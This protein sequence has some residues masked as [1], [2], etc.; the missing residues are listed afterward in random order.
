MGVAASKIG[1]A[2]SEIAS[3]TGASAGAGRLS[4]GMLT[5]GEGNVNAFTDP[6]SLQEGRHY[7][8]DSANGKTYR[9]KYTGSS[10]KTHI[11]NGPEFHLVGEEGREA[12]IDAHTTRLMQ[13]DDP[14]IWR[15][16]Q[17]LYNGGSLQVLR[18]RSRSRG[19]PAF[20]DGNLDDFEEMGDMGSMGDTGA[21]NTE[22]TT[23][24]QSVLS[25]NNDLLEQLLVNGVKGVFDVYGKGGL[26]DSYDT[27]KR[28]VT[29]YG[30][31]Y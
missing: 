9:A 14:G 21:V 26:V 24:L 8:V 2:K 20:A 10:P 5:Y 6:G 31:R 7:N 23:A 30:Q 16:I 19:V 27:G 13:M 3:V 29:R 18:R 15:T 17:T 28:T 4:T 12:I 11:T 25:R 22:Q 1:K